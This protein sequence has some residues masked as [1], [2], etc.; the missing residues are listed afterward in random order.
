MTVLPYS[1][2]TAEISIEALR[3]NYQ[4]IKK[5]LSAGT[6]I[7]AVVKANAYGHGAVE[8]TQTLIDEGVNFLCV[9]RVEEA[10]QLRNAG[11]QKDILVFSP[12]TNV[13]RSAYLSYNLIATFSDFAQFEKAEKGM[14]VHINIDTGMGRLG[15]LYYD[16]AKLEEVLEQ[17]AS[18]VKVE[19]I[20]THFSDAESPEKDLTREQILRFNEV[21]SYF[22]V[23]N[24]LVHQANSASCA[25]ITSAHRNMVRP[26]IA[27]YG[28]DEGFAFA[29]PLR[30]VLT[31]KSEIVEVRKLPANWPISYGAT[32]HTNEEGNVG[33]V[34]VGYGDGLNRALSGRIKFAD[35][36]TG[37]LYEQIG[38]L[39][40]DHCMIWLGKEALAIG[41]SIDLVNGKAESL[42]AWATKLNTIPYELIC[43]INSRVRRT[44]N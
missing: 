16:L 10:I 5:S 6:T 43:S 32:Y 19:G 7:A 23:K 12:P 22:E 26:G 11:I 40:M 13:T 35:S 15:F 34:A 27:L 44:H 25:A 29:E 18:K 42:K 21:L 3:F 24:W 30:P 9:A 39:T 14:R 36:Q 17:F 4:I 2:S 8:V 20:Y 31:W 37:K 33:V 1:S 41:A 28:Y 38:R